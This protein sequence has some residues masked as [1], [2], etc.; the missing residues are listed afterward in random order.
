M[1]FYCSDSSL[2]KKSA[3]LIY[4]D[5]YLNKFHFVFLYINAI[6][7]IHF[8]HP[9]S[10]HPHPLI[11]TREQQ[12]EFALCENLCLQKNFIRKQFFST[13]GFES[14]KRFPR[15]GFILRCIFIQEVSL[16]PVLAH[17]DNITLPTLQGPVFSTAFKLD[18]L[19]VMF[20]SVYP[21]EHVLMLC[22]CF[23]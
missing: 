12:I 21:P 1:W 8:A 2:N 17:Q 23:L 10:P 16:F 9:A 7:P 6:N 11:L 22:I 3:L 18:S 15:A 14:A 5:I 19:Q 20:R 4:S 13:I